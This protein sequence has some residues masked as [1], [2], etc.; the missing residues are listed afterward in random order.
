MPGQGAA[1]AGALPDRVA[2]ALA[3][4]FAAMASEVAHEDASL[5]HDFFFLPGF[6]NGASSS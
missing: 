1:P 3:D 2:P 6:A 5:D 4:L